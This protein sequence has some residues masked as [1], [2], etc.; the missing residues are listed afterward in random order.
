MEQV[1]KNFYTK[2]EIDRI[3]KEIKHLNSTD[4]GW[5]NPNPI[6]NAT[7]ENQVTASKI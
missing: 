1:L 3:W 6:K 7:D 5:V 2:D 4:F